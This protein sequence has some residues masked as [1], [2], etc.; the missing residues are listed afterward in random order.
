MSDIVRA[1]G[2][3]DEPFIAVYPTAAVYLGINKAVIIQQLHYLLNQTRQT[4]NK[5][6]DKAFHFIEGEWWVYNSYQDWQEDH[7]PWLT[8]DYIG[9]LFNEL[10]SDGLIKSSFFEG[11]GIKKKWYTIDYV[12]WNQFVLSMGK[13]VNFP[14]NPGSKTRKIPEVPEAISVQAEI[15]TESKDKEKDLSAGQNGAVE[16]E[17]QE[18][19]DTAAPPDTKQEPTPQPPPA[20]TERQLYHAAVHKA[21]SF[22]EKTNYGLVE[23]YANFLSGQTPQYSVRGKKKTDNGE[24]WV[25]QISDPPMTIAE[26]QAFGDWWTGDPLRRPEA[27]NDKVALFRAD[28]RYGMLVARYSIAEPTDSEPLSP[29][30][31]PSSAHFRRFDASGKFLGFGPEVSP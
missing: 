1:T 28:R 10:E 7:F 25:M 5:R 3:I 11:K 8:A 4:E 21:L 27:L 22:G 29:P 15:T 16:I 18:G 19:N 26:V 13:K 20:P 9:T 6:G 2:L 12:S 30:Q 24:W 31:A 14:E 23:K 17:N